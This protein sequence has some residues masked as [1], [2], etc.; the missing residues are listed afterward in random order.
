MTTIINVLLLLVALVLSAFISRALPVVVP[1]PLVQI[2]IGALIALAPK[3]SVR[4]DPDVF[5]LLIVPPLL[6]YDGW[7]IPNE[8]LRKEA[9]ANLQ[10][11]LGLVALTVVGIGELVHW[12]IPAVPLA[13]CF[14][15]AAA[16]SPTDA[17]AVSSIAGRAALPRR[18]TRI[19]AGESLLNDAT[20]LVCLRLSIVAVLTGTFSIAT[21]AM[22]FVWVA[23]IGT[24]AGTSIALIMAHGS[25][26]LAKRLGEEAGLQVIISLLIPFAAYLLA[27]QLHGSGVLAAVSAGVAMSQT[28]SS[29][30]GLANTRM[31]RASVWE[32]IHFTASGIAFLLLGEQLPALLSATGATFHA[33]GERGSWLWLLSQILAI[34]VGLLLIRTIWIVISH[35]M[36]PQRSYVSSSGSTRIS[37]R[38]LAIMVFASPRGAI[39]L[40]GAMTL[41]LSLS[42][43]MPFPG[44]DLVMV[45]AIGVIVL[46]L[47]IASIAL[48]LLLREQ[49]ADDH[50]EIEQDHENT[51]RVLAARAALDEIQRL[52]LEQADEGP[53][54][55]HER[56]VARMAKLYESV[57][58]AKS[59]GRVAAE[60]TRESETIDRELRVK[61]I[62]AER[63]AIFTL[64]KEQKIGSDVATK[65]IRELDLLETHHDAR[66]TKSTDAE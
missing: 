38:M 23:V 64:L 5:F 16:I 61:T 9:G 34:N 35:A 24:A 14:A 3:F 42:N 21:A 28:D 58:E 43:G 41:P 31:Q 30:T 36:A 1:R 25:N 57:I 15:F 59:G 11:S 54:V 29:G 22:S 51:A 63:D 32:T 50:A 6:F 44:R 48:P 55:D 62:Q 8:D 45:L 27:E 7:R 49:I 20:A 37:G 56:A 26:W 52:H 13:V 47:L 39:T 4:L 33:T 46:S 17:I 18:L 66:S 40:A 65:I 2:A 60:R 10:L 19:L 53:N 12:L